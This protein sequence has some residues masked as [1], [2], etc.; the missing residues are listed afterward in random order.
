MAISVRR[1]VLAA[2]AAA[3]VLLLSACAPGGGAIE[4]F[5]G[6]PAEAEGAEGTIGEPQAVWLESGG[7][8]AVTLYGSSTCPYVGTDIRVVDDKTA[9][10]TVAVDVPA[11]PE[12]QAC[13]MDLVPHTTVF[14]TPMN[15]TTTQ[16]LT[17]Q[18]MDETLT[19][20]VK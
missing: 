3:S 11:L 9:G 19:I 20:P 4:D 7:K 15:V 6:L 1:S 10:N 2:A 12:D 5:S 17:V 16:D 18:V 8:I 14:W 13:T